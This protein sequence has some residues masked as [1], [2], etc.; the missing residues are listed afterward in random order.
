MIHVLFDLHYVV[1]H[2]VVLEVVDAVDLEFLILHARVVPIDPADDD[3][4]LM[5]S[6]LKILLL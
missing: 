5:Q 3:F 1:V 2:P 4:Q 6:V